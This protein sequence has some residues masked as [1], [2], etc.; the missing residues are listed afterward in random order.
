MNK[1]ERIITAAEDNTFSL[2]QNY[3]VVPEE[4]AHSGGW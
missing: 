3:L 1:Y 4:Y 2:G